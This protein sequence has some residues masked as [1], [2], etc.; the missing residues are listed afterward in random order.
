MAG[1]LGFGS[2][3][4]RRYSVDYMDLAS[5]SVLWSYEARIDQPIYDVA[6]SPDGKFL[7]IPE[8]NIIWILDVSGTNRPTQRLTAHTDDVTTVAW[9]P[10]GQWLASGARDKQIILWRTADILAMSE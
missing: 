4:Y 3:N 1:T 2:A 7:A 10:D 8:G 5:G 6:W 9:S